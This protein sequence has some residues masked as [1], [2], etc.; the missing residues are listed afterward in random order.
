MDRRHFSKTLAAAFAMG[1]VDR[2]ELLAAAPSMPAKSTKSDE[3]SKPA[4][5]KVVIDRIEFFPVRY[6]MVMRFKFFETPVGQPGRPA[7]LIKITASDGTTGWGE[8]VPI[9][10]WSGETLEGSVACLKNYLIP[11]LK[12]ADVFDLDGAH[13]LMER[14]VAPDFSTS[15]PITKCGLDIALHDLKGRAL[16]KNIAEL[17]G[18]KTPDDLVLSWTLNPL[19]LGEVEE[20]VRKGKERGYKNFN[21][22]IAPDPKFDLELCRLVK[23][24]AL[25]GFLWADANGGYDVAT[26]LEVAPRLADAGVAVLE[27]PLRPNRLSGYQSLV[28]QGALPILMDEGCVSPVEVEEFIRLKCINGVAMKPARCGGLTSAVA[29]LDLLEKN[30]LLFLGSGLTDPDVSLAAS[31]ILYGAYG[32]QKPAALNG[33]QFLGTSV[34]K[35]PFKVSGGKIKIPKGPGLGIEVDEEKVRELSARTGRLG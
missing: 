25:D 20:L 29:Q 9:P 22:K 4:P 6:P 27:G 23:K 21:V 28:K 10:R 2:R 1:L 3:Q 26:A 12:G 32:L 35:E 31:L 34:L 17:W 16:G 33:P 30:R 13:A 24:L 18:R 5:G 14:E 8:S 19:K 7:I 11:L 15:Y